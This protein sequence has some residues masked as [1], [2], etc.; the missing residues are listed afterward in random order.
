[1]EIAADTPMENEDEEDPLPMIREEKRPR[2]GNVQRPTILIKQNCM[3]AANLT[4]VAR[5]QKARK[6]ADDK[7]LKRRD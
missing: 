1:M 4:A 5:H 7:V 6:I 2:W 3:A